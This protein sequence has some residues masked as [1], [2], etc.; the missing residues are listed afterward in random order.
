MILTGFIISL[1]WIFYPKYKYYLNH[2]L[3]KIP[4]SKKFTLI[5]NTR[6]KHG[7]FNNSITLSFN[8]IVYTSSNLQKS[9]NDLIISNLY[10]TADEKHD[11]VV[12]K[13]NRFLIAFLILLFHERLT[14]YNYLKYTFFNN[15]TINLPKIIR[16]YSETIKLIIVVILGTIYFQDKLYAID[17]NK[18]ITSFFLIYTIV[19][20]FKPVTLQKNTF[21]EQFDQHIKKWSENQ[22]A[23]DK[24]KHRA[25]F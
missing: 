8:G 10:S 23:D 14:P 20:I 5:H 15:T 7:R 25:R 2:L 24:I 1:L 16:I 13:Y 17:Q 12:M 21:S 9:G 11:N 19:N 3:F 22:M 18:W 6:N 4:W